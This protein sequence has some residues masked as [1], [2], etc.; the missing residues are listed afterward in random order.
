MDGNWK[1][2]CKA[3]IL[4]E[5]TLAFAGKKVDTQMEM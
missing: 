3:L 1:S 4:K 2:A 5:K